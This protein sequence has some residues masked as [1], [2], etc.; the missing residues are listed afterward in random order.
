MD[1]KPKKLITISSR[2]KPII[3]IEVRLQKDR[4]AILE[5][6]RQGKFTVI[7]TGTYDYLVLGHNDKKRGGSEPQIKNCHDY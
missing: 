2:A 7:Q 6:L 4:Q 3:S 1:E 5:D